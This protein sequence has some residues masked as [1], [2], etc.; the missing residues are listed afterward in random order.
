[1]GR[2]GRGKMRG[3]R[4]RL[5]DDGRLSDLAHLTRGRP[6]CLGAPRDLGRCP[7]KVA[8][9]CH[10]DRRREGVAFRA[11]Q[12]AQRVRR[13]RAKADTDAA[14]AEATIGAAC[15]HAHAADAAA[16][17]R[18]ECAG[19]SLHGGWR[20]DNGRRGRQ[21]LAACGADLAAARVAAAEAAVA[22][23]RV[24]GSDTTA[25]GGGR[26]APGCLAIAGRVR[27]RV[28]GGHGGGLQQ[29]SNM[30]VGSAA[31]AGGAE[32]GRGG[33]ARERRRR[34]RVLR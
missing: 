7:A 25:S 32:G 18:G 6:E 34:T 31:G 9:E 19:G 13:M 3:G 26:T 17:R 8:R 4:T 11:G 14:R 33:G 27:R 22:G 2:E 21:H 30:R 20:R 15:V 10:R 23:G 29:R 12:P 24:H 1:M 5:L 28:G 16:N